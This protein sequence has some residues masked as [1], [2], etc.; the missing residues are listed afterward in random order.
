M[1]S[2][3]YQ[4]DKEVN[5]AFPSHYTYN[6]SQSVY[7]SGSYLNQYVKCTY[8]TTV[9]KE[10]PVFQ[11]QK[12]YKVCMTLDLLFDASIKKILRIKKKH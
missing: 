5:A 11:S 1:P 10:N 7:K 8:I 2:N 4:C 9:P 6:K 3:L 12:K